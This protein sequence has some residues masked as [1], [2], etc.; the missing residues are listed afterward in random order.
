MGSMPFDNSVEDSDMQSAVNNGSA[1]NFKD[2]GTGRR[3]FDLDTIKITAIITM[4]IDHLAHNILYINGF[5]YR[6]PVLIPVYYVMRFI[7]RISFP[8]FSFCLIQG[9]IYTKNFNRYLL[10]LMILSVVSIIPYNLCAFGTA[11]EFSA[12]TSVFLFAIVLIILRFSDRVTECFGKG[13]AAAILLTIAATALGCFL[14]QIFKIDY[15]AFGFLFI[16]CLY[17][18]RNDFRNMFVIAGICIYISE[19]FTV[20]GIGAWIAFFFMYRY[21]GEKGKNLGYMPYVFYPVHML[22]IAGAGAVLGMLI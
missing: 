6:F 3:M 22:V 14:A 13:S 10:R 16:L 8:L 19:G 18:F 12:V 5:L 1:G 17:W 20:T 11:F 21:N 4:V 2:Y 9:Y 7:G 15:G